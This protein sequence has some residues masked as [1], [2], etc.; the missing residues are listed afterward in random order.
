MDYQ[1]VPD[2][3]HIFAMRKVLKRSQVAMA[4][5]F[6]VTHATYWRWEKGERRPQPVNCRTLNKLI[7]LAKRRDLDRFE[8]M[9]K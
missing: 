5:H 4:N 9:C 7:A 6:G 2:P 1:Q 3:K 8:E